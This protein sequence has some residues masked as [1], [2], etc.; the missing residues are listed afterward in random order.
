[1]I[2]HASESGADA[3]AHRTCQD[4]ARGQ[5]GSGAGNRDRARVGS[6]ERR[7]DRRFEQ[8]RQLRPDPGSHRWVWSMTVSASDLTASSRSRPPVTSPL[9]LEE[10]L[11][12]FL[13]GMA[14][15]GRASNPPRKGTLPSTVL[16]TYTPVPV[17]SG[18]FQSRPTTAALSC[19]ECRRIG[20][21]SS[22][23]RRRPARDVRRMLEVRVRC[24]TASSDSCG[25]AASCSG[26]RRT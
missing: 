16:K 5:S 24:P 19:H 3:D 22:T 11:G 4:R 18:R 17:G 7:P 26:D 23:V 12:R 9:G 25:R 6:G 21:P 1:M 15:E 13:L 10:P 20:S 8:P 14:G 2:S